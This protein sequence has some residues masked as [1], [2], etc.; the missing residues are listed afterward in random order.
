VSVFSEELHS[1]AISRNGSKIAVGKAMWD[2]DI[3]RLDLQG[4]DRS[5]ER[6]ISSTRPEGRAVFSPDG[7]KIALMS[8]RSGKNQVWV[9]DADGSKPLQLTNMEWAGVPS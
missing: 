9:V 1:P 7:R 4:S 8:Y 6:F 5:Q 2:T 3:W